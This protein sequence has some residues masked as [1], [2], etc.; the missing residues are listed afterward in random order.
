[1]RATSYINRVKM[2]KQNSMLDPAVCP[3]VV[4]NEDGVFPGVAGQYGIGLENGA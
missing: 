4:Y 1:M 3:G 2:M